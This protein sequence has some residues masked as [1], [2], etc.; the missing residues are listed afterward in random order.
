MLGPHGMMP[1]S[2]PSD[3]AGWLMAS[4]TEIR[5]L[6]MTG[7]RAGYIPT[8]QVVLAPWELLARRLRTRGFAS[9][10]YAVHPHLLAELASAVAT[11]QSGRPGHPAGWA[12]PDQASWIQTM[13]VGDAP[14]LIQDLVIR[15]HASL[16]VAAQ[17]V[18]LPPL[19][20]WSQVSWLSP[21]PL[22]FATG[23]AA[24][25]SD[26]CDG[27]TIVVVIAGTVRIALV[28]TSRS[29]VTL[30]PGGLYLAASSEWPKRLTATPRCR[31]AGSGLR[32][33]LAL[34]L[35]D[36]PRVDPPG[37]LA[38]CPTILSPPEPPGPSAPGPA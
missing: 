9:L 28:D 17:L 11:P 26:L 19:P 5:V 16:S 38:R 31:V 24:I 18:R 13:R 4:T 1:P 21:A 33:T 37:H 3:T 12:R 22:S 36:A 15:L 27:V 35:G 10:P 30:G 7:H 32:P 23:P 29:A 20:L 14:W 25:D 6:L 2:E 34:Q 8:D